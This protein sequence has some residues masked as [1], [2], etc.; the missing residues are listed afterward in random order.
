MSADLTIQVGFLKRLLGEYCEELAHTEAWLRDPGAARAAVL[1]GWRRAHGR[2]GQFTLYRA[3]GCET[4]GGTGYR[5][6]VGL[7]ELL[8]GS[9]RIKKQIQEHARVAELFATAVNEGMRTLKMDG[10]EKV[11]AG[12]TDLKQVRAV[13]IK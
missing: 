9:D 1:E 3:K 2:E 11:M 4:C 6:R 5:G 7:H 8:T 13:C 10:I 12:V